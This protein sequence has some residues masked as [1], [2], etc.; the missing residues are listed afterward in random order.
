MI[1]VSSAYVNSY[2]KEAHEKVYDTPADVE[3]VIDLS[4]KLSDQALVDME[5]TLVSPF[6]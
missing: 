2:L 3:S 4:R 5:K 1:H 6:W